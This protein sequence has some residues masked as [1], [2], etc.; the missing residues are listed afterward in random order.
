MITLI[1][2]RYHISGSG[3]PE[4]RSHLRAVHPIMPVKNARLGRYDKSCHNDDTL[5][6]FRHNV[7]SQKNDSEACAKSA[8]PLLLR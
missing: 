3:I 8:N 4:Y 1:F 5:L 7:N 6:Y 2:K